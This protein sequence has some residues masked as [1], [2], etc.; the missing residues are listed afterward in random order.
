MDVTGILLSMFKQ[1]WW[2]FPILLLLS[3]LTSPLIK[4]YCGELFVKLLIRVTLDNKIW[5]RFHNVTLSSLDGTTQIDHVL[6]SRYGVFVIETKNMRGWIFGNAG[7]A[8]WTQKIYRRSYKF[9]N[10]LRQNFKHLKALELL[11]GIPFEQIHSVIVFVGGSTF[12]TPMPANVTFGGR[13]IEYICSFSEVVFTE[14]Q[15]QEMSQKLEQGKHLASFATHQGHVEN[16]HKRGDITASR[17][18]PK[19]G[20]LVVI[21]TVKSGEKAGKQF[22]GCST[23]PKCRLV[24]DFS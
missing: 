11:L 15:V 24:Q 4:G 6:I 17:L 5:Q 10:P 1:N 16:L 12:K 3:F 18:C 13:V 2:I 9:Q 21:R 23:Y 19:C 7:Q 20:S 14:A 8:T 22:W